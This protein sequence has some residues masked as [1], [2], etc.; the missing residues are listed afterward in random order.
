MHAQRLCDDMA[1]AAAGMPLEQDRQIGG[2]TEGPQQLEKPAV[3]WI[4]LQPAQ[5]DFTE[6]REWLRS[7]RG[8]ASMI[9]TRLEKKR[10]PLSA[11]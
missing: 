8:W 9:T 10:P 4:P 7:Q 2:V 6:V 5:G 1:S 3:L 11:V